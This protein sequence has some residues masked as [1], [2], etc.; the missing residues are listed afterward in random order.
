MRRRGTNVQLPTGLADEVQ[1]LDRSQIHKM[2]W[3]GKP[4]LHHGDQ[5]HAA[6]QRLGA[7]G[8][9]MQRLVERLRSRVFKFLR[10]HFVAPLEP[11]S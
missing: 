1:I 4:Q 7:A 9:Q 2:L 6:G 3:R 11:T 5:A 8:E 10:D